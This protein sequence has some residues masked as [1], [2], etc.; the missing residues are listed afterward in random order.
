MVEGRDAAHHLFQTVITRGSG[1]AQPL[2]R[3]LCRPYGLG[4]K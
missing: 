4:P 1:R 3:Q 2:G